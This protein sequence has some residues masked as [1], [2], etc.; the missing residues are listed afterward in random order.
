MRRAL[1][2][3]E[4]PSASNGKQSSRWALLP[5]LCCQAAGGDP[6]WADDV[7][8]AWLLY[9]VA[10]DLMD[11]VED[12]DEPD[13]W[14]AGLGPGFALNVA[15][16]LYFSASQALNHLQ[17]QPET[18]SAASEVTKS[19]YNSFLKMC[20]GQHAD[21]LQAEPTLQ[22]YWET[23]SG[24]SG[25]FF[26]LACQAG[27]RLAANNGTCLDGYAEFGHHLGL[28]VQILDDL[29]DFRSPNVA[30]SLPALSSLS[31]SLPLAYALEVYPEE[32]GVRLRDE[33]RASRLDPQG[34]RHTWELIEG[35][36]AAM[37]MLAE[38]E[39]HRTKALIA[40][41]RANPLEPAGEQLASLIPKF[42]LDP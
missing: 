15:S 30:D 12:R 21:L 34:A 20:N 8:A 7:A 25:V 31:R 23:A 36:G 3:G 24:K 14:W 22:Q 11:T 37:Y 4:G 33:L 26:S 5:G 1:Q 40:L 39:R 42:D 2:P 27:A 18:K 29:D 28:L 10:A 16:G 9:Y 19:F 17:F 41:Q 13:A 38:M 32:I 6:H 35:S